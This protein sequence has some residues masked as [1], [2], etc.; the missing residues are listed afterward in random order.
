M[1]LLDLFHRDIVP[2]PW[3]EGEKI[4]WHDPEFSR[5]MLGQ[6]LSQ[7]H[8]AASRRASIIDRQVDWIHRELLRKSPSRILD[9]GCGP[10]FYLSRF[11]ALGHACHGIDFSPASIEYAL[12]HNQQGCTYTLG[13]IR[14]TDYGSGYDVVMLI[15]GEFNV[16]KSSDAALILNNA[17]SALVSGGRLLLELISFDAVY[18]TGNQ[19]ATWYSAERDLFADGPHICLMESFW[20]EP[21]CVAMERYFIVDAADGV[22][23]RYSISTQAYTEVQIRAMLEGIGFSDIEVH[24]SLMGRENSGQPE[25]FVVVARK[26]A[27]AS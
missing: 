23:T 4:P 15:Y 26:D 20:D 22:V 16:F 2:Q 6:H 24:P 12:E 10:G 8:D 14:T 1:N 21:R 27:E 9:L 18:E 7:E 13:D 11:S 17:F 19:P 25:L 3:A 5:R